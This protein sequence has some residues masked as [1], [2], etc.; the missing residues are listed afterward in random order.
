MEEVKKQEWFI[1]AHA[2]VVVAQQMWR[3][4]NVLGVLYDEYL[5]KEPSNHLNSQAHTIVMTSYEW[6]NQAVWQNHY[7]TYKPSVILIDEKTLQISQL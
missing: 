1:T 6:N 3:N 7:L 4:Y 5:L 2:R